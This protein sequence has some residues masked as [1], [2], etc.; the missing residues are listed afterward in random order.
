MILVGLS[1][2][3]IVVLPLLISV[4]KYHLL[5]PPTL[6]DPT[7][8]SGVPV[9]RILNSLGVVSS[10]FSQ[11]NTWFDA[12]PPLTKPVESKVKFYTISIP[13]VNMLDVPIE[14]N[15]SDLKKNAIHY[16]GSAMPGSYGNGVIFGHSALPQLYTKDNPLTI[17]NPLTK[18]KVG[19][20][21]IVKYDGVTYTYIIKETLEVT[22]DKVE[23]MAQRYDRMELTL[24]TCVPLG[25]YWRRFV[26]HADLVK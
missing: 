13:K 6:I 25:T 2:L 21:V 7:E 24:I 12:P 15:G 14:V 3:S 10:D 18:V 19:D 23:V 1:L 17:F 11:A 5:R 8:V 22:P 26:V 4:V 9:P 16:P 20:N